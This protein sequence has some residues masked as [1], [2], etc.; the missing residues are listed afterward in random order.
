M[1]FTTLSC[2]A[3]LRED[4]LHEDLTRWS[5]D[6]VE[7]LESK[8]SS[9]D[10]QRVM[11]F[12]FNFEGQIIGRL[13]G[14]QKA[15]QLEM[16]SQVKGIYLTLFRSMSIYLARTFRY[17]ERWQASKSVEVEKAIID[18]FTK[19]V[20]DGKIT[21]SSVKVTKDDL[22]NQFLIDYGD[23]EELW[24]AHI[25]KVTKAKDLMET[26]V[27]DLENRSMILMSLRKKSME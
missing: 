24:Q 15:E 10:F 19:Y 12:V 3:G 27:D 11:E 13:T 7:L 22:R 21:K 5:E 14:E 23:Q 4:R 2:V 18:R 1:E 25:D 6:L 8:I 20:V 16:C 17:H 9:P 26:V